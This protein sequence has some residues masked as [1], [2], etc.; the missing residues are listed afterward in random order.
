MKKIYNKKNKDL[1]SLS[2]LIKALEMCSFAE[3]DCRFC[4]AYK[5]EECTKELIRQSVTKLKMYQDLLK[6]IR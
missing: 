5:L 1:L 2:E 3:H 4:P 6:E